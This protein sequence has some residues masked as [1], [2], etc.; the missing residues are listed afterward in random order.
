MIQI[1]IYIDKDKDKLF[2]FLA[3]L[4]Y[5]FNISIEFYRNIEYTKVRNRIKILFFF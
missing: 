4:K 1:Y 2:F 5:L 3:H